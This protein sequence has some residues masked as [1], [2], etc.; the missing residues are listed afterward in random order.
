MK[1]GIGQLLTSVLMN[2]TGRILAALGVGFVSYAGLNLLQNKFVSWMQ[3]QLGFFPLD[4]LQIFYIAGGGVFLNWIFG[5]VTFIATLKS[6]GRLTA[7]IK[8]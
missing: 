5:A 3:E 6:A 4:A 1:A 8:T 2:T 7:A